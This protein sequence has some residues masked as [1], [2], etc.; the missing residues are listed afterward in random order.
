MIESLETRT[1]LSGS[2]AVDRSVDVTWIGTVTLASNGTL[3]V[4]GLGTSQE[5]TITRRSGASAISKV[6]ENPRAKNYDVVIF[7][8][9]SPWIDRVVVDRKAKTAAVTDPIHRL[10]GDD[11]ALLIQ[12]PGG[13]NVI[14]PINL[15]RRVRVETLGGDD[16]VTL[17]GVKRPTTVLG[18][19]GDDTLVGDIGTNQLTLDGGA[20]NDSMVAQ[21][22][23]SKL[24]GGNGT[25]RVV[26]NEDDALS[27]IEQ[28]ERFV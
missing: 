13:S 14:V 26:A 7:R 5:L 1:L 22:P 6:M 2:P 24:I 27:G 28:I 25:D 19:A 23:G 16:L 3:L 17:K 12:A 4:S 11:P 9:R 8:D 20:G 21:A 15:V 18:G 10:A